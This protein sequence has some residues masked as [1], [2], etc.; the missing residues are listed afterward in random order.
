LI[1]KSRQGGH[2]WFKHIPESIAMGN[3]SQADVVGG[4]FSVRAHNEQCVM[5]FSLH[6]SGIFYAL[7]NDAAPKE[8]PAKLIAWLI[9]QKKAAV[10]QSSATPEKKVISKGGRNDYLTSR[11]GAL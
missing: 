10:S 7:A 5:P 1:T 6:P 2:R 4:D 9:K 8:A 3:I 11:A